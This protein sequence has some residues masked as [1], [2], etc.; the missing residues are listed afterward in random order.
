MFIGLKIWRIFVVQ[1]SFYE[2]RGMDIC[3]EWVK[4]LIGD[5]RFK[6]KIK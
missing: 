1:M 4:W 2:V 6:K 5:N 3:L